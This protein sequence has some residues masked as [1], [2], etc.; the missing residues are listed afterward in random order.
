MEPDVRFSINIPK[1]DPN[2]GHAVCE[3]QVPSV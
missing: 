2:L 1:P 3:N